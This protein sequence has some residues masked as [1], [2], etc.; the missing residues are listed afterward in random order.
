MLHTAWIALLT[1]NAVAGRPSLAVL[2]D[3]E[4]WE[5]G[6]EAFLAGPPG[7]WEMEGD[8]EQTLTLHRAPDLFSA[9]RSEAFPVRGTVRGRLVDGVWQGP[10]ARDLAPAGHELDLDM[11]VIPLFGR[12]DR[13]PKV[14]GTLGTSSVNLL[15]RALE[16]TSGAV[17]T[18]LAQWDEAQGAVLYLRELPLEGHEN[19]PIRVT[20]RFPDA[21]PADRIDVLWPSPVRAGRWPVV[22]TI[23]D[24]RMH[25]AGH[26]HGDVV[27]PW[28]ERLSFVVSALGYTLG[29]EQTVTWR[30]ATPCIAG[31]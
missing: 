27:L 2:D 3:V 18:S 13:D 9:G 20:V 15:K 23:R 1:A 7:C 21:G 31:A 22:V 12:M 29:F 25:A 24:A 19:R 8:A 28:T 16:R 26:P 30:T 11:P 4:R 10:L 14:A 5:A 6:Q 17:E